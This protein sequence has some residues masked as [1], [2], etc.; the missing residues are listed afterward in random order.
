MSREIFY[1]LPAELTLRVVQQARAEISAAI[2]KNGVVTID[3]SLVETADFSGVQL[4]ASAIRTAA[5]ENC[6]L[7]LSSPTDALR[8]SVRRAGLSY[9]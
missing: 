4:L 7:S 9:L 2:Q 1:A 5:S 8:L 3:C 6:S